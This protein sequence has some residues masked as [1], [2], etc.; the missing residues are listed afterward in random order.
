[1]P[2]IV[3]GRINTPET[4]ENILKEGKADLVA[5]GRA[6][7]ADPYWPGKALKGQSQTIRRCLGCSQGCQEQLVQ[8][9]EISCI[10]N[11][12]VG[13]EGERIK[14]ALKKKKVWVI[15]GGPAGMEAAVV[16][17]LRGHCVELY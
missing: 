9:K 14:P 2:L 11:P 3:V 16:A 17:H 6:L 5:I 12:G 4:A 1:M 10:H 8:E 15:G 13:R 7:I